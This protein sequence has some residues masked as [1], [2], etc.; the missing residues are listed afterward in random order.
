MIRH[1]NDVH[2]IDSVTFKG[3]IFVQYHLT[4]I[5]KFHLPIHNIPKQTSS[6]IGD[7]RNEIHTLR[8]IVKVFPSHS[9]SQ[10]PALMLIFH[11][12]LPLVTFA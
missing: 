7:N 12:W 3:L 1:N 10:L 6:L 2:T 8:A 9:L 11:N 5:I 4:C